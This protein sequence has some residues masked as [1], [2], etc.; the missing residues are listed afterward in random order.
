MELRAFCMQNIRRSEPCRCCSAGRVGDTHE[1]PRSCWTWPCCDFV[2]GNSVAIDICSGVCGSWPSPIR[3]SGLHWHRGICFGRMVRR[4]LHRTGLRDGHRPVHRV[5]EIV[6]ADETSFGRMVGILPDQPVRCRVSSSF[7]AVRRRRARNRSNLQSRRQSHFLYEC[8]R[9]W[10]HLFRRFLVG[11][12]GAAGSEVCVARSAIAGL[13]PV[14]RV[15]FNPPSRDPA[16]G[17]YCGSCRAAAKWHAFQG[18]ANLH[19]W[20]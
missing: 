20:S 14:G 17:C 7:T 12:R 3:P 9:H 2:D 1:T 6:L 13:T 18:H 15:R 10:R 11:A 19:P 8:R 4:Q 16:R 5:A